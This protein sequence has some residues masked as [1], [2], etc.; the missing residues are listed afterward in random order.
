MWDLRRIRSGITSSKRSGDGFRMVWSDESRDSDPLAL[1]QFAADFAG[2]SPLASRRG[3]EAGQP[4]GAADGGAGAAE[5]GAEEPMYLRK[6]QARLRRAPTRSEERPPRLTSPWR[7]RTAWMVLLA[8]P[9]DIAVE[10]PDR[11][12]RRILRAP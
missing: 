12:S 9:L 1:R 8:D 6:E 4:A 11:Q 2:G 3:V 5:D 10:A 7:L